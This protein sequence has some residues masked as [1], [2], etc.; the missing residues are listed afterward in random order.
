MEDRRLKEE[1]KETFDK[2]HAPEYL[3]KNI[4]EMKRK[5]RDYRPL[6]AF[7]S[8]AAAA[9]A[10]FAAVGDYN[11]TDKDNGGVIEEV[12]VVEDLGQTKA[13]SYTSEPITEEAEATEAPK[14]AVTAK[15]AENNIPP[16]KKPTAAPKNKSVAVNKATQKPIQKNKT[17]TVTKS[18]VADVYT[19][20]PKETQ[21]VAPM[22]AQT[23]MVA[24]YAVEDTEERMPKQEKQTI[25]AEQDNIKEPQT[26]KQKVEDSSTE[27]NTALMRASG[28]GGADWVKSEEWDNNRYFSYIGTDVVAKIEKNSNFSYI[29][30]ETNFVTVGADGEIINDEWNFAFEGQNGAYIN[31]ITSK[32]GNIAV[33]GTETVD[34]G[35]INAVISENNTSFT[36]YVQHN[37]VNYTIY[38]ASVTKEEVIGLL[39]GLFM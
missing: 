16:T 21:T 37:G 29:G 18:D 19:P 9:I 2:I 8:T 20:I 22:P 1:F 28:G 32:T 33:S 15:P 7:A 34:I 11:F 39:K 17:N 14:S 35:G 26:A 10:I 38:S 3:K 30:A 5:K 12:S 27:V 25:T 23:T 6:I 36:C 4:L 24:E 31:I 13:P